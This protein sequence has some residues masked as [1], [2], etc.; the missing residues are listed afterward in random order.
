MTMW[1]QCTAR[2]TAET[3]NFCL[4]LNAGGDTFHFTICNYNS[5][6]NT[7]VY[8]IKAVRLLKIGKGGQ[9]VRTI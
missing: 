6:S 7:M 1:W 3:A 4:V 5:Q 9:Y 2:L 8:A